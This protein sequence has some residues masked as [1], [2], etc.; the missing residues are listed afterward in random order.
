[1]EMYANQLLFVNSNI[2]S[3]VSTVRKQRAQRKPMQIVEQAQKN[4]YT[5]VF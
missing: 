5:S 1:M 3:S 2:V 4:I